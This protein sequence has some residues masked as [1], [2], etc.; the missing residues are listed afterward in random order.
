M[1][2]ELAM[3]EERVVH[4]SKV[5]EFNEKLKQFAKRQKQFK[6]DEAQRLLREVEWKQKEN[7]ERL[8]C[9]QHLHLLINRGLAAG[10]NAAPMVLLRPNLPPPP[11]MV[12]AAASVQRVLTAEQQ[13]V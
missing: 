2:T 5:L 9:V 11:N 3:N 12:Q 7:A 6:V 13:R 4:Q 10:K 8:K 1:R